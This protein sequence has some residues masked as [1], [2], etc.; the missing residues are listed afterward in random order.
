VCVCVR[1]R[2]RGVMAVIPLK[3]NPGH[4]CIAWPVTRHI[5]EIPMELFNF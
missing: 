4:A 5:L 3:K 2:E 1:E